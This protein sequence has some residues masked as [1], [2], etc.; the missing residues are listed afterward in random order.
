[1]D[2]VVRKIVV[3][4]AVLITFIL[5]ATGVAWWLAGQLWSMMVYMIIVAIPTLIIIKLIR[6][7]F[8]A[9]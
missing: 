6:K 7:I 8:K 3:A 5:V 1:M 4:V 9:A 2:N